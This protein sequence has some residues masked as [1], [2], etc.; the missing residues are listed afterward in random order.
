MGQQ[1]V[2]NDAYDKMTPQQRE[3]YWDQ[4][5][6]AKNEVERRRLLKI[7]MFLVREIVNGHGAVSFLLIKRHVNKKCAGLFTM[8]EKLSQYWQTHYAHY[9]AD[10]VRGKYVGFYFEKGQDLD[11]YPATLM[12]DLY[13]YAHDNLTP[14]ENRYG[15]RFDQNR[16]K[17][18]L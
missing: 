7:P 15:G 5:R 8:N 14:L 17:W 6:R 16:F 2:S 3:D 12:Q 10:G 9:Q 13:D 11:F 1:D 4:R 18:E